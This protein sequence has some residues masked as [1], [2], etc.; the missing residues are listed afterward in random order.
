MNL[1]R[2]QI[3]VAP[4]Y[5]GFWVTSWLMYRASWLAFCL[6]WQPCSH[7]LLSNIA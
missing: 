6:S 4:C 2:D 1:V 7:W 5:A 3:P